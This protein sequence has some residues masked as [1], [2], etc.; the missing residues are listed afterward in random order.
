MVGWFSSHRRRDGLLLLLLLLQDAIAVHD[1]VGGVRLMGRPM[2]GFGG[3][4]L[5]TNR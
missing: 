3:G 2:V 5:G 4:Y 1:V